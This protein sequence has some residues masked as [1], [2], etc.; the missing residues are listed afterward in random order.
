[1]AG[2][3]SAQSA[4]VAASAL[5]A[6][7]VSSPA[8]V[9][10]ATLSL[11][12][13]KPLSPP[14]PSPITPVIVQSRIPRR[15]LILALLSLSA[16]SYFIDGLAYLANA[17]F[18]KEWIFANGVELASVVGLITYGGLAALGAWKDIN[19]VEVWAFKRVKLAI[20][21]ALALDIILVIL[22]ALSPPTRGEWNSSLSCILLTYSYPSSIDLA[23]FCNNTKLS[24]CISETFHLIT[25][26]L[27]I[28]FLV[29][30][31][32]ALHSPRIVYTHVEIQHETDG[33]STENAPLV[34]LPDLRD[35]PSVEGSKYGT[36]V[37]QI[38]CE[39]GQAPVS[40][41]VKVTYL[42]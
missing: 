28:I 27:R 1:M 24:K 33:N 11:F 5:F 38:Q 23:H 39:S 8:V 25:P 30:L 29:P 40:A 2:L 10:L 34:G 36:F 7:R 19:N 17:I 18:N 15:V 6:V 37:T 13:A 26:C 21:I 35:G 41:D 31:L 12:S 14:S 22:F 16:L 9:L 4:G 20:A 42:S 32:F 3:V